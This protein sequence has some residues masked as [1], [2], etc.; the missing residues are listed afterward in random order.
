MQMWTSGSG[1]CFR[2]LRTGHGTEAW[3]AAGVA[4][5]VAAEV[6]LTAAWT[7]GLDA[8]QW[9]WVRRVGKAIKRALFGDRLEQLCILS[10]MPTNRQGDEVAVAATC[11]W[12][13]GA[14]RR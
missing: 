10:C 9:E 11:C 8:D 14:A 12:K 7:I 2:E 4:A 6:V 1:R 13:L 3:I 5:G